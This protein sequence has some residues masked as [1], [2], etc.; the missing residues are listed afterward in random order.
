MSHSVKIN[1]VALS[2]GNTKMGKVM[3]V[4]L[5]PPLSCDISMPCFRSKQCYAMKHVYLL[6]NNVRASWDGNYK[7]WVTLGPAGYFGAIKE[8]VGKKHPDLFRWHV[9]GDIPGGVASAY[10]GGMCNVADTFPDI[11]FWCFTK[12]YQAV[13]DNAFMIRG[14]PNL[15]V[16]L[17]AWPG[18]PL[19]AATR[20]AWPVCYVR[21]PK[22][23][24]QRIPEDAA[25]CSGHCD[26]CMVCARLK[27]GKSVCILK[28]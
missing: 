18:V 13:R 14:T 2:M 11:R 12:R 1:G 22:N 25:A 9:G 28:H 16:V 21:D 23:L 7:A 19:H 5:P 24:D 15:N 17:S 10:I 6:Y 3:S 4:S 8:A 20:K 26:Q 27:P